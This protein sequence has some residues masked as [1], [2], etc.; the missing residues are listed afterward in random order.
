MPDLND[1]ADLRGPLPGPLRVARVLLFVLAAITLVTA[2][3]G[4]AV[5]AF[6]AT[7][8]AEAAGFATALA[9]P[10]VLA[11]VCGLRLRKGRRL[12]L[13]SL[14]ALMVFM[15]LLA[16][17]TIGQGDPRGLIQLLLPSTILVLVLL[18]TSRVYL[19]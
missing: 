6:E 1:D 16:L 5:N 2:V 17:S 18:P 9:L 8:T 4:L 11:M 14:A 15:I 3:A 7:S 13:W 10:G 12:L 19:K